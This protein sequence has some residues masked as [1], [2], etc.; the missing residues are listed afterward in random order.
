MVSWWRFFAKPLPRSRPGGR[1]GGAA[2]PRAGAEDSAGG[3]DR[4]VWGGG[5]V[6]AKR[7]LGGWFWRIVNQRGVLLV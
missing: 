5:W 7:F 6:E 1:D 2:R 4:A 3:N